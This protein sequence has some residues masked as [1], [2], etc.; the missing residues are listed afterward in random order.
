MSV[1][2]WWF[3]AFSCS[4]AKWNETITAFI[5]NECA[6]WMHLNASECLW[7]SVYC[8]QELIQSFHWDFQ[9]MC[10][11]VRQQWVM[12]NIKIELNLSLKLNTNVWML[13]F[14]S[15]ERRFSVWFVSLQFID[16]ITFIY[17]VNYSSKRSL[18]KTLTVCSIN[19]KKTNI[20]FGS[21]LNIL[22]FHNF[23]I[24]LTKL[25]ESFWETKK[26]IESK[27]RRLWCSLKTTMNCHRNFGWN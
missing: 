1:L 12:I 8:Q 7:M 26:V 25:N 22:S 13:S 19:D 17:C 3:S 6:A 15:F 10:I 24:D 18:N 27:L 5:Y 23:L 2:T 16:K 4:I 11:S 20:H 14:I 21:A 9:L